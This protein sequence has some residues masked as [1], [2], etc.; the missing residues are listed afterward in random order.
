MVQVLANQSGAMTLADIQARF[1]TR[2]ALKKSL[3]GILETL[4]ALGRARREGGGKGEGWR[5][6]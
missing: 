3:P 4:E 5:G 6:A 2:S 1:K